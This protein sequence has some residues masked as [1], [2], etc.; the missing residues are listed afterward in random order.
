MFPHPPPRPKAIYSY[1][2]SGIRYQK[3]ANGKTYT[4]T[5]VDGKLIHQTD[6]DSIW[7][8]YYDASDKLVAMEYNGTMYY[9]MYDSVGN[10]ISLMDT[11]GVEVATYTYD[12]W[13]QILNLDELSDIAEINPMRYKGYYYDTE[14]GYYYL[15]S[16]YY[17]PVVG[18]FLNADGFASTGQGVLGYNMYAYCGNNPVGYKDPCGNCYFDAKGN[19]CHDNWEYIGNY[20]RKPSPVIEKSETSVGLAIIVDGSIIDENTAA[21]YSNLRDIVII[22]D[23]RSCNHECLGDCN[24]N[25]QIVNSYKFQETS[26]QKE[27]LNYLLEYNNRVSS[28][29]AW[30]RT[31]DS[32]MIEWDAHN[33][34][35]GLS[36][37]PRVAHTDFDKNDEGTTWF[38]F[39]LRAG[40]EMIF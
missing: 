31:I 16:R 11:N 18:R 7:W 17:D 10:I 14:T 6:G 9:Y 8:F 29:H 32:L 33:F 38:E 19:W 1:D 30:G 13:G 2:S 20:Q 39:M 3:V 5:Y 28:L 34:L 35:F 25:M 22:R 27:L 36:N 23:L 37:H 24:P 4:F 40:K 26:Q 12:A 15:M 21:F